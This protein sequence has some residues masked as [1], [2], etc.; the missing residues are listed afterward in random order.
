M[1]GIHGA[2]RAVDE[3]IS[4]SAQ[5]GYGN[6]SGFSMLR[7]RISVVCYWQVI[8]QAQW[9]LISAHIGIRSRRI[10]TRAAFEIGWRSASSFSRTD[11]RAVICQM[12]IFQARIHKSRGSLQIAAAPDYRSQSISDDA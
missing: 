10:R 5:D 11:R 9:I 3:V 7:Q 6:R 12:K 8:F 2:N 4:F 1:D